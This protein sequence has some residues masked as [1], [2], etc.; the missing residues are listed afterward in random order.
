[1]VVSREPWNP[2]R[3][4]SQLRTFHGSD[5]P[6]IPCRKFIGLSRGTRQQQAQRIPRRRPRL[7]KYPQAVAGAS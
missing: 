6:R 2:A 5:L 7:G 4:L 3:F 1:M